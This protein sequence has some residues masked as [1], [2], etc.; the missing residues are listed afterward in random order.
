M[1]HGLSA[2]PRP[3]SVRAILHRIWSSL[4]QRSAPALARVILRGMPLDSTRA[5]RMSVNS[6]TRVR[7]RIVGALVKGSDVKRH[8]VCPVICDSHVRRALTPVRTPGCDG[9]GEGCPGAPLQ[10]PARPPPRDF[11]LFKLVSLHAPYHASA[12]RRACAR[13]KGRQAGA[14]GIL[15][16]CHPTCSHR[17][18]PRS[19]E[20]L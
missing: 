16:A 12:A 19:Q 1:E 6:S 9:G 7:A 2:A 20:P 5:T 8:R 14:T 18:E 11:R 15:S 17:C 13:T 10:R 4:H 3:V